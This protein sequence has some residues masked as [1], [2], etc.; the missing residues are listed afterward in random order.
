[1]PPDASTPHAPHARHVPAI[2]VLR[3]LPLAP[4][5]FPLPTDPIFGVLNHNTLGSQLIANFIRPPEIPLLS[6]R[7][8]LCDQMLNLFIRQSL[9]HQQFRRHSIQ[10]PLLFRPCQSRPRRLRIAVRNHRKNSVKFVQDSKHPSPVSRTNR[11]CIQRRIHCPHQFEDRCARF[12]RIQIVFER[13]EVSSLGLV[14][15]SLQR[16]G[17]PFREFSLPEPRHKRSQSV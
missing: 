11:P 2:R 4:P 1:M 13:F 3:S 15:S 9:P 7:V 6:R 12:S 16:L 14:S 10:Q 8:P 5:L 17:C